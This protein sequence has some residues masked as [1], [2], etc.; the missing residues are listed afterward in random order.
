MFQ[1]VSKALVPNP[2]K[3]NKSHKSLEFSVAKLFHLKETM[4]QASKQTVMKYCLS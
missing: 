4:N 2:T 3:L 1:F